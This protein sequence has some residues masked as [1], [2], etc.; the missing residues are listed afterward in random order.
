MPRIRLGDWVEDAVDFLQ[1]H[2]TWFFDVVS[3]VISGMYDGVN[4]VISGPDPLVMAAILAVVAVGITVLVYGVVGLIVKMDDVG[5]NLAQRSGKAVAA[6]G[7]GLVTGM[8][9]LLSV[10][11]VVGTAASAR[12]PSRHAVNVASS[13]RRG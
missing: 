1:R 3:D 13:R 12:M 8:P 11:T 5:L 6:I 9:K 2:F 4:H 10:L 7:R